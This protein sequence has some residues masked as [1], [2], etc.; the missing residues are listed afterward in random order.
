[1]TNDECRMNDEARMTKD[2]GV[3]DGFSDFVIWV[4]FVIRHSCF[5][6]WS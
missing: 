6:I 4:S 3:Q 2:L 5:V 1:M